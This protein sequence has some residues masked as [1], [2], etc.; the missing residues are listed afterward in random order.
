MA[1][2]SRG[3]TVG[4]D[5][6]EEKFLRDLKHHLAKME[7]ETE[8]DLMR[9][10]FSVQSHA[11]KLCPVDTGRLRSSII[12]TKGNDGGGFYVEIGTNVEY[13][14]FV[15]FGTMYQK[16]QPFL[17]PAVALASGFLRSEAAS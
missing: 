12:V 11:R 16:A 8:D 2:P 4:I 17:V 1:G 13:A 15:E 6:Q 3:A 7:V 5:F 9:V 10:G 14:A